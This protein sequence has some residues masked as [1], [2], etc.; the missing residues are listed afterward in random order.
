MSSEKPD[1]PLCPLC[2]RPLTVQVQSSGSIQHVCRTGK[3]HGDCNYSA[4]IGGRKKGGQVKG[5]RKLTNAEKQ[6]DYRQR[7]KEAR[8]KAEE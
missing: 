7:L 3:R 6:R 1:R 2:T 4:T 5:D 8:S